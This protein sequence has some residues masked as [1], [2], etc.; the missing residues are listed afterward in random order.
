MLRQRRI[1]GH[2]RDSLY[3][4]LSQENPIKWIFMNRRQ[5]FNRDHVLTTNGQL[6]ISVV[7]QASS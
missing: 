1:H 6:A 2:E 4:R 5:A 7:E 3:L